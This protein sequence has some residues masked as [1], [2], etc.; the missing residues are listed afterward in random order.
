VRLR[1]FFFII[2]AS[3]LVL[4][5]ALLYRPNAEVLNTQIQLSRDFSLPVW[6]AF[7]FVSL[8]S[9]AVPVIFGLLRDV[10]QMLDSVTRRRT[11]R[12]QKE[13]E[14]LYLLGIEAILGG[15]EERALEHFRAVLQRDAQHFEA[16]LKSG[17]VCRELGR[18][19]EAVDFHR[20]ALRV[21]ESDLRPLFALVEDYEKSGDTSAARETLTQII[22]RKPK[23]ALTACRKLR[24]LLVR[25]QN[26]EAALAI[27]EKIE[28]MLGE[29]GMKKPDLRFSVGIPYQL[30]CRHAAE[31]RPREAAA[32][33]RRLVKSAPGFAPAAWK[34]GKILVAAGDADEAVEI[35]KQG[36]EETASPIFLASL[37]DHFLQ[38][39]EPERAIEIFKQ[40]AWRANREVVPR[41]FLGKLYYR[42]EMLDEALDV[43]RALKSRVSYAP[44]IHFYIARILERRGDPVQAVREYS[45]LMNQLDPLRL[46]YRCA[47]CS[48][49]FSAW[50]DFCDTCG[51]WNSIQLDLK[52]QLTVE[53]MG[54]SSAPVY[55]VETGETA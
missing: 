36:F 31:E 13:M 53:E 20:R 47:T 1:T 30:A 52:E 18:A 33:L 4:V 10:K 9:M 41:F 35:W 26:W 29:T 49:R 27:Q 17:D 44:T 48:S 45:H 42:L 32:L 15:R 28:A 38:M 7:L 40:L 43:F 55:N 46:E 24:T 14:R 2:A 12:L 39:E 25:D 19:R 6:A 22:E 37:E 11:V 51:E 3:V 50:R 8:A 5:L 34:L 21:R 16:L 23:R 54:I